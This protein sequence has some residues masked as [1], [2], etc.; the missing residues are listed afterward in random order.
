MAARP[1]DIEPYRGPTRPPVATVADT[2]PGFQVPNRPA[3]LVLEGDSATPFEQKLTAAM[4]GVVVFEGGHLAPQPGNPDLLAAV[5]AG[6]FERRESKVRMAA[7]SLSSLSSTDFGI[8]LRPRGWALTSTSAV[9]EFP[10]VVPDTQEYAK[11]TIDLFEPDP[12]P[13]DPAH[14]RHVWHGELQTAADTFRQ[15]P[16]G[17]LAVLFERL[18]G[19]DGIQ[20]PDGVSRPERH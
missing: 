13:N 3:V 11:A 8:G 1:S 7:A 4:R 6:F 2:A 20:G 10:L 16:A 18:A 12:K 15:D 9:V 14:V 19:P 5:R 17:C